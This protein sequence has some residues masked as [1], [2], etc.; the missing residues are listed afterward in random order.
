MLYLNLIHLGLIALPMTK[1]VQLQPTHARLG[2]TNRYSHKD[3]N[4]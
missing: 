1:L 4:G 3:K 2:D